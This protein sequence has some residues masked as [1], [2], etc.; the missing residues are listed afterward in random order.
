MEIKLITDEKFK[1]KW[2]DFV[3]QNS[4]PSPFLQSWEYS[5]FVFFETQN[6]K[7]GIFFNEQLVAVCSVFNK[8]I[9]GNKFFLKAPKG[10]VIKKEF[11]DNKEILDLLVKKIKEIY[12]NENIIF[13]R[14]A[15]PYDKNY[16]LPVIN[17]QLPKIF[18]NLKE[19]ENT[20]ILDLTKTEEELFLGMHQKTRYNIRL[21]KK[22]GIRVQFQNKVSNENVDDFYLI[23]KETAKR[24]KINI[25]SK[26]YY[27]KFLSL[28]SEDFKVI[29]FT[30][31][32]K[33][34]KLASI[35]VVG[36]G[37]TATY[38]FGA[39]SDKKRN[40]MPNYL[41]QWEAIR[42]AKNNNYKYYD[43]WGI[44][45]QDGDRLSGVTRFKKGFLKESSKG[46]LGFI[47]TF[48]YI[49]NKKW[50]FLFQ[51]GKILKNII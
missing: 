4:S 3:M 9:R 29:L 7:L 18:T 10:L 6:I 49:L 1:I 27:Q 15:P 20:L 41:V 40:L 11:R 33:Q 46:E 31:Y 23:M 44:S 35:I 32:G 22:K 21:A 38:F 39:S 8:K 25:F 24:D 43:F 19:P 48:D 5:K 2:N 36:F 50:Y 34:E 37:D 12:V 14:I 28:N 26:E 45:A 30:A 16:Q 13:F 42:W 51:I 17:Y 47:G